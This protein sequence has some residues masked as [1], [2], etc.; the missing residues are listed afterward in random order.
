MNRLKAINGESTLALAEY[1]YGELH[2][3]VEQLD[4]GAIDISV[5]LSDKFFQ[6]NNKEFSISVNV[7]E[8]RVVGDHGTNVVLGVLMKS[9]DEVD[10]LVEKVRR[11][12]REQKLVA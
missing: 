1:A 2:Q 10:G 6:R 11:Y 9:A 3:L 5:Y 12:I 8:H 4:N 7:Y